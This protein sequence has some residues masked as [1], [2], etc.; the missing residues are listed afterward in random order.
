MAF[1]A[2]EKCLTLIQVTKYQAFQLIFGYFLCIT[3]IFSKGDYD[4][5]NS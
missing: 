3:T 2:E 1:R 5:G 4:E